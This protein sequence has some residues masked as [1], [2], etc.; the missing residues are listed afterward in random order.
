[1][2]L[3]GAGGTAVEVLADRA[4]GLPPLN[5]FLARDMIGRTRIAALLEAYRDL[6][7]ADLDAIA[8]TLVKLARMAI[9]L[10]GLAELDINPLLADEDGVVALDSRIRVELGSAAPAQPA[11][12]PYPSDLSHT[13]T[14]GDGRELTVRPIRPEDAPKLI[15][16]VAASAAEDVRLRFRAGLRRLPPDWA[17]RTLTD[18][19]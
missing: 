13:I 19:L 14:A 6:P 17:A 7:A 4:I 11:I 2:I 9:E 16:M 12:R 1:M 10:E 3:F 18:R 8:D 15:D 5:R